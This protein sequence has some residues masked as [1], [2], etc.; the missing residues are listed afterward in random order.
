M[1]KEFLSIL[2]FL[3]AA[4]LSVAQDSTAHFYAMPELRNRFEMRDGYQKL[5]PNKA[6]PAFFLSQR[7]RLSLSYETSMLKLKFTPQDVRVWGDGQNATTAG[8]TGD[9]A[10]LDLYEG[11]AEINIGNK[12][13]VSVGRQVLSYDNNWL[14]SDRNW[15]QSGISSD[16][17]VLKLMAGTINIHAG[18]TWNTLK[19]RLSDNFYPTTRYK[20]L[21]YMWLNKSFEKSK[22]SAL[23]I[24][25]GQT[26]NDSSNILNFKHTTGFFG[27]TEINKVLLN[28]NA[29][30]QYGKNQTGKNVAALL[31]VADISYKVSKFS[32]CAG[33]AYLSGNKT[34]GAA[35][36][37]DANFDL[38]YTARHKFLGFMDYF[39][40]MALHT[41]QGG[42]TDYTINI[43]FNASKKISLQNST[44]F[45]ALTHTNEATP[46]KKHLGAE[47][48][49]TVKYK[50]SSW[51]LLE[52]GYMF[53]NPTNALRLIQNAPSSKYGQFAF[54]QLVVMPKIK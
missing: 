10:S 44:H 7:T 29:Y 46:N 14:L 54:L 26:K 37:T 8:F 3:H 36:K 53:F 24:S 35:Q 50:F 47:N 19:E 15:S 12:N 40:H 11:Y 30:Y 52:A 20:T 48:D 38:I 2:L 21:N 1:K 23:H 33:V 43:S 34:I 32:A 17:V 31:L 22:L 41:K 9:N 49:F 25:T 4:L 39:T 28:A 16:A 6:N 51:G 5:V 27:S 42:L 13:W 18:S 45:F